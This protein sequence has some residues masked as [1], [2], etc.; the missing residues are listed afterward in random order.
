MEPG[1][2]IVMFGLSAKGKNRIK[3]DG[4]EW[5]FAEVGNPQALSGRKSLRLVSVKHPTQTRWVLYS[6]DRHFSWRM[7]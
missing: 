3:R 2:I 1:D 4:P 7:K 5:T 6:D